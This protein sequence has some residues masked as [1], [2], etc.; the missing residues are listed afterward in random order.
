MIISGENT[1]SLNINTI[2]LKLFRHIAN[3]WGLSPE[4]FKQIFM[5]VEDK[6]F[7]V[8]KSGVT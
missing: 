2:A 7:E 4:Q 1:I 8:W 3:E 5:F 6:Q